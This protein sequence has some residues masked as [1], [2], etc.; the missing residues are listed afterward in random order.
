MNDFP[1]GTIVH[2]E[3]VLLVVE[4]TPYNKP[5]CTGCYF[6][7]WERR[8]RGLANFSCHLHQ[9]ACTKHFRK[10]RKHVVFKE[11]EV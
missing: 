7:D 4:A 11:Y 9:M 6:S 3:K 1:T 10:D 8:R 2:Y 5:V